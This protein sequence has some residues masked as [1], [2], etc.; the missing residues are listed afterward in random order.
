[1]QNPVYSMVSE[2]LARVV[3][4]RAADNMLRAALRESSLVPEHVT[5]SEMQRVLIG[6]LKRRLSAL[7][8]SA[9]AHQELGALSAELQALYPKAPT[10][11]DEPAPAPAP[12]AAQSVG[13]SVPA[14]S[15]PPASLAWDTSAL[16]FTAA[17]AHTPGVPAPETLDAFGGAFEIELEDF[18]L[19]EF[20]FD[21]PD[22]ATRVTIPPRFYD[23]S[24]ASG[25]DTLLS[26][27]ARFDGV[28]GVVLCDAQGQV[29]RSRV[30]RG[31]EALGTV[32]AAT[33]RAL[34]QRP[35]RILCA[36]LGTQTVYVRPL[37]RHVVALLTASNTNVGRVIGELSVV[38]ESV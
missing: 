34:G 31:A 15:T 27:L 21:D 13:T 23:L 2:A 37:G 35:W 17:A 5:A 4:E 8:P 22:D 29:V 7:M 26:D 9:L 19:D 33:S 18:D 28:Q 11:F 10:L 12:A 38:K 16:D 20:E 1:M 30:S 36:D 3:S 24:S 14:A 6:P 32:M 25:Q